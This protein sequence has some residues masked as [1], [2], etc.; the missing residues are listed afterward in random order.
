MNRVPDSAREIIEKKG[1]PRANQAIGADSYFRHVRSY[2]DHLDGPIDP[3]AGEQRT[4]Q[5]YTEK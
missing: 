3:N 4:D 1:S 5:N 2:R